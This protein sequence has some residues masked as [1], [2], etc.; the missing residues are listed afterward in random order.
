MLA[1]MA[2][3]SPQTKAPAPCLDG[4]VEVDQAA[5]D[6]VAQQP[7]LAALGDGVLQP[8]DGQGVLGAAVD[9]ALA[10]PDGVGGDEHALDHP[11]G[12][13]LQ[14]GPVHEGPG[15]AFVGVADEVLL[16][17]RGV[18]GH[19]P[20]LP[21]GETGAAPSP[22]PRLGHQV[23]HLLAGHGGERPGRGGEA[24]GGQGGVKGGRIDQTAV[25]EH[26]AGLLAEEGGIEHQ[27][28]VLVAGGVAVAAVEEAVAEVALLEDQFEELLHVARREVAVGEAQTGIGGHVDEYLPLA[29]AH[30]A[31]LHQSHRQGALLQVG[32]DLLDEAQGPV[33]PAAGA[34][35][36]EED[37][38]LRRRGARAPAAR[39]GR[40]GSPCRRGRGARR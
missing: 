39:R 38:A 26:H 15:V 14:D 20:L 11:E 19:A 4:D 37:D 30:A 1:R 28:H 10:R 16:H 5:Q 35:A 7:G 34:G 40:R 24:A 3:S 25:L 27:G 33:G 13:S 8:L 6:V 32:L 17:G 36:H 29:V 31:D 23:A 21:R 22:Q 9:V 18:E 2:V 12:V